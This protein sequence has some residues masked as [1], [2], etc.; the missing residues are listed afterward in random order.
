MSVIRPTPV[1]ETGTDQFS[2]AAAVYDFTDTYSSI[3]ANANVV[4][5]GFAYDAP[6]SAAHN[7]TL[8]MAASAAA[9][10]DEWVVLA[11]MSSATYFTKACGEAGAVVVPKVGSATYVLLL[12]TTGKDDD[13][14]FQIWYDVRVVG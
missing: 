14:T 4:L 10:N 2:A 3:P 11:N 5:L 13:G 8:W 6:S 12:E 9:D 1:T 7:A